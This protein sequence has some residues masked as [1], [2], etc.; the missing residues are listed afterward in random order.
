M[1]RGSWYRVFPG[2]G[3]TGGAGA[4][5]YGDYATR[6]RHWEGW[7][8]ILS[9]EL[10]WGLGGVIINDMETTTQNVRV[11]DRLIGKGRG[12]VVAITRSEDMIP[13]RIFFDYAVE[14]DRTTAPWESFRLDESVVLEAK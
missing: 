8:E 2:A 5:R 12:K 9:K 4:A 7:L 3:T 14:A 1:G 6:V 13:P 11:G 10:T